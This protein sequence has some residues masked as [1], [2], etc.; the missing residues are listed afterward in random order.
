MRNVPAMCKGCAYERSCQGGCK[1][2][3]FATFGDHAH[4]EPLIWLAQNPDWR[5][6]VHDEVPQAVVPLRRLTRRASN[7]PATH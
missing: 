2:S 6:G 7:T 4:V 3:A 5:E 1:E